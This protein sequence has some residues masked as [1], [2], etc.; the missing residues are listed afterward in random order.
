MAFKQ[1]LE[2]FRLAFRSRRIEP[3]KLRERYRHSARVGVHFLDKSLHQSTEITRVMRS[4]GFF[5]D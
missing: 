3:V 1:A 5:D 4:R 2:N